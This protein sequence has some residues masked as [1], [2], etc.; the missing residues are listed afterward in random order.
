MQS[1]LT[2]SLTRRLCRRWQQKARTATLLIRSHWPNPTLPRLRHPRPLR[3]AR[4]LAEQRRQG[5]LLYSCPRAPPVTSGS[6]L[7]FHLIRACP[8][9]RF[10]CCPPPQK[11]RSHD[12]WTPEHCVARGMVSD[13]NCRTKERSGRILV[14]TFCLF[15]ISFSVLLYW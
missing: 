6:K 1:F 9:H 5:L 2:R 10:R 15:Y 7:P 14:C 13:T 8:A 4:I 11:T 12:S 3:A